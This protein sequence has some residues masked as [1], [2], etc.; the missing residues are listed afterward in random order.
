MLD[1]LS[2]PCLH[3]LQ[4]IS[5]SLSFRYPAVHLL[6]ISFILGDLNW[7]FLQV[8]Y[9]VDSPTNSTLKQTHLVFHHKVYEIALLQFAAIHEASNG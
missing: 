4:G 9:P 8:G 7:I 3:L 2:L 1:F 5:V 6:L